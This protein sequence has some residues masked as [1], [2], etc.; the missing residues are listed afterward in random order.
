MTSGFAEGFGSA[1]LLVFA[2]AF[3]IVN[4]AGSALIFFDMT[5]HLPHAAR[6]ELARRI[7][8]YSFVVL[9][10][11]LYIGSYVLEFFGISIPALRVAGGIV[12]AVAGWTFLQAPA[13]TTK[14]ADG[15][16]NTKKTV[17]ADYLDMA[18]YPLTMPITTGPGTMSVMIALGT[19]HTSDVSLSHRLEFLSAALLAT[20]A[21]ALLVYLCFAFADRV[22]W[23]LGNTGTMIAMRLTAFIL[24]CIG[25]QILWT[26]ISQMVLSLKP[27]F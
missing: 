7:A 14:L 11:S 8:F 5:K 26:G 1:C 15:P 16:P 20:A 23:L 13:G 2:T 21:M 4:P 6:E 24:F 9:N 3:P 10:V 17:P 12:V 19:S 27:F 22:R 18:F 25:I